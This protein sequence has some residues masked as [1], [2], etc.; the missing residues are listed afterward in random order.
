[1]PAQIALISRHI[2]HSTEEPHT[3]TYA[4]GLNQGWEH[5]GWLLTIGCRNRAHWRCGRQ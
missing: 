4:L 3:G 2:A 1:M 5:A